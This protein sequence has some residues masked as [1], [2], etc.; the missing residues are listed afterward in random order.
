[1]IVRRPLCVVCHVEPRQPDSHRCV[2]CG[3]GRINPPRSRDDLDDERQA[4]EDG[5]TVTTP[6]GGH[7]LERRRPT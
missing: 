5:G 7:G 6:G 1:M 3:P 4:D 2:Y